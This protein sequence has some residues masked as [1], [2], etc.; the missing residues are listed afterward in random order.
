ME[1]TFLNCTI[2]DVLWRDSLPRLSFDISDVEGNIHNISI[3]NYN[4][5][6]QIEQLIDGSCERAILACGMTDIDV[7]RLANKDFRIEWSPC[8]GTYFNFHVA[9]PELQK[10]LCS[11]EN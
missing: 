1:R 7:F 5:R 9:L 3:Q 11:T 4:A 10:L 2:Q 8:E 6:E